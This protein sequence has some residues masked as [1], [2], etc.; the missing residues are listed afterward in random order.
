MTKTW[1]FIPNFSNLSPTA[2]AAAPPI[3]ASTSSKIIIE[4][5][6]LNQTEIEVLEETEMD[7][8]RMEI[9][10]MDHLLKEDIQGKITKMHLNLLKNT[11]IS[12]EKLYQMGIKFCLRT[13]YSIQNIFLEFLYLKKIQENIMKMHQMLMIA[14]K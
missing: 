4:D 6:D 7:I 12:Q 3:P 5:V 8:N 14:V 11:M 2:A 9:L 1:V 10:A 13:T